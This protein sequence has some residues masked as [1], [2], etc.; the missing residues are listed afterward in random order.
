ME[1]QLNANDDWLCD[2][3][4]LREVNSLSR[5]GEAERGEAKVPLVTSIHIQDDVQVSRW[6]GQAVTEPR[7]SF[8]SEADEYLVLI[9]V[10][11]TD[12]EIE[13]AGARV[14]SGAMPSG[15][16]YVSRQLDESLI[17][18]RSAFDFVCL[19][20]SYRFLAENGIV[21]DHS[22]FRLVRDPTVE[23]LTQTLVAEERQPEVFTRGLAQ[24][25]ATRSLI[26]TKS[27]DRGSPLP[28]WRLVKLERF[29]SSKLH[30][31]VTLEQMASAVGLSRMHFAKSFRLATGFTP[32]EYLLFRRIEWAKQAMLTSSLNLCEIALEAGFQAQAHFSTVFKRFTGTSPARWK[33]ANADQSKSGRRLRPQSNAATV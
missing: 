7:F 9:A 10:R 12:I 27:D 1:D 28:K 32:H 17:T 26:V 4:G 19:H 16:S 2:V 30:E 5:A 8:R 6:S 29:I 18:C 33:E 11:P 21:A 25:L 22:A 3:D 31:P 23:T 13:T 15:S 24:A 14:F 20:I